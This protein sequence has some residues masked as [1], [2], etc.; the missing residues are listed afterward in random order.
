MPRRLTLK[1]SK[2]IKAGKVIYLIYCPSRLSADGIT[3]RVSFRRRADAEQ[4]RSKLFAA[5]QN[6]QPSPLSPTETADA[7]AAMR[8]L[9][10]A[11]IQDSLLA[12]IQSA[13]PLLTRSRRITTSQMFAEF[14]ELKTP[15]WRPRSAKNYREAVKKICITFADRDPATITP[16]ELTAWLNSTYPSASSIAHAIRTLNPAFTYAQRQK[17]IVENPLARVEKQRTVKNKAI[18]ILTPEE[19][20]TLLQSAPHDCIPAYAILLFAGVRPKELMRLKWG[21]IRD[22]FIHVSSD[23]AKTRSVRNIELHPTLAAWLDKYRP[24]AAD[25]YTTIIPPDWKRKD[26]ATRAAAGIANRPDVCRHSYA[27]YY[28]AAYGSTDSLKSNM[29]HSRGSDTLF[30]HYRAATTPEQA[31]AYWSIFPSTESANHG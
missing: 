2:Q 29:G 3:R 23:I 15:Q 21:N 5:W 16:Q 7:Q 12:T 19:A 8:V 20:Q 4:Y 24:K 30:V 25:D 18:D 9:S 10:D 6:Q 17:Y 1:I 11:G 13:L 14:A 27:T 22:N 26:Q 31:I 28:L